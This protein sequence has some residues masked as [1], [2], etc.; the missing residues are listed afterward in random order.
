[1]TVMQ[2]GLNPVR[3]VL[4]NGVTMIA[5]ETRVT[6]AVTIHATV[7]TGTTSDPPEFP[8]FP[9]S[10]DGLE[11]GSSSIEHAVTTEANDTQ[12]IQRMGK[13]CTA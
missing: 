3:Q 11:S 8:S 5:K 13:P 1:M 6:P 7:H 9:P 2:A 12:R 4:A 10:N